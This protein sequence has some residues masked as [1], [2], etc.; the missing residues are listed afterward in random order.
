MYYYKKQDQEKHSFLISLRISKLNVVN[1]PYYNLLGI[2]Y[3]PLE[4]DDFVSLSD[5]K[6]FMKK[7]FSMNKDVVIEI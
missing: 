6:P 5:N 3:V 4:Q 2:L 1:L 7:L